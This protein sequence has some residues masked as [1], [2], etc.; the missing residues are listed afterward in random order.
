M[1]KIIYCI[2]IVLSSKLSQHVHPP[3]LV[4]A[5]FFC[6]T[7]NIP[8]RSSNSKVTENMS[9]CT[10][11]ATKRALGIMMLFLGVAAASPE[12]KVALHEP[13]AIAKSG[14]GVHSINAGFNGAKESRILQMALE[15]KH[16]EW[17]EPR[18]DGLLGGRFWCWHR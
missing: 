3:A 5:C 7:I 8:P 17:V 15:V 2:S 13:D 14:A 9:P 1:L 6:N 4:F 10:T 11:M 18:I 12:P 16:A